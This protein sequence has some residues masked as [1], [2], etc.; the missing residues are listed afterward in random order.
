MQSESDLTRNV[1]ENTAPTALCYFHPVTQ[2]AE[3]PC[4]DNAVTEIRNLGEM[5]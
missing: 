1:S 4:R 5:Q 3:H 2:K